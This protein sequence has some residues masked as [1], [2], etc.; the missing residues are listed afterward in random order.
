MALVEDMA[1]ILGDNAANVI[2]EQ[3]SDT[4]SALL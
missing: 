3:L 4:R 2:C 1:R